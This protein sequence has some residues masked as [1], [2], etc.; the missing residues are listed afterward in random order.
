MTKQEVLDIP[1][2]EML[3][4]VREQLNLSILEDKFFWLYYR[5]Q[6]TLEECADQLCVD[7]QKMKKVNSK[8][9]MKLSFVRKI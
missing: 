8:V 7:I 4:S 1:L 6:Y 2:K 9:K 3:N 5:D